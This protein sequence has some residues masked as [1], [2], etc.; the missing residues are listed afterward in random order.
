MTDE[1]HT[2]LPWE[3]EEGAARGA[4]IMGANGEWGALACGETDNSAV[5]NTK[6]I[7][8]AVNSHYELLEALK[9]A[10][11]ALYGNGPGNPKIDAAIWKAEGRS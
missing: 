2:P 8:R 5:E 11:F 7:V 9:D 4:W 3:A 1:K 6:F 10:R